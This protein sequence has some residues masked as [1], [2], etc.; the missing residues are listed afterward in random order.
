[1]LVA[2]PLLYA[3]FQTGPGAI[4]NQSGAWSV[5]AVY[6]ILSSGWLLLLPANKSI[7]SFIIND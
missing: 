3:V 6:S 2:V 7:K 4:E 1:L 5:V